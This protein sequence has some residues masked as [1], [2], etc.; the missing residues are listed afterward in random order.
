M[1]SHHFMIQKVY[2]IQL[3]YR[4]SYLKFYTSLEFFL[5][6]RVVPFDTLHVI[7]FQI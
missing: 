1:P 6:I 4:A 5:Y 3:I 2:T 7:V